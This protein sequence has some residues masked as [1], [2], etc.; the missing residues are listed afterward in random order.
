MDATRL[1]EIFEGATISAA[2]KAE[3]ARAY[4][5]CT[6]KALDRGCADCYRDAVAVLLRH[7]KESESPK[8]E[9]PLLLRRGVVIESGGKWYGRHNAPVALLK[10]HFETNP[11]DFE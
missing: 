3:V 5:E 8:G 7:A 2:E 10:K 6:G 9:R 4:K 1:R 11:Q